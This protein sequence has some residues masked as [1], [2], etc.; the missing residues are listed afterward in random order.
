MD[1][2]W[3]IYLQRHDGNDAVPLAKFR[4]GFVFGSS[5]THCVV[6]SNLARA[7]GSAAL[8]HP[9]AA[10]PPKIQRLP[11]TMMHSLCINGH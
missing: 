10:L 4:R 9:I 1:I 5:R 3:T 7:A 8:V 6:A 2:Q 11:P